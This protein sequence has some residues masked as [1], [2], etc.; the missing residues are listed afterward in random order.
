MGLSD[1]FDRFDEEGHASPVV[2]G[3]P[4][5]HRRESIVSENSRES[6]ASRR[7]SLLQD[8]P[9]AMAH[10][11]FGTQGKRGWIISPS[12]PFA[13]FVLYI[14]TLLLLYT[15]LVVP[16]VVAFFWDNPDPCWRNPLLP[17]DMF[18]DTFFLCE[19]LINFRK[20][21]HV[22]GIYTQDAKVIAWQ[23]IKGDLPFDVFTSIPVSFLE[24]FALQGCEPGGSSAHVNLRFT[25]L[26]KP[27]RLV[28]LV[29]VL[30]AIRDLAVVG[31]VERL[32]KI[33]AMAFRLVRVVFSIGCVTHLVSCIFWFTKVV[34]SDQEDVYEFLESNGLS[35]DASVT[36]KYIISTY[37][38][39]TVFTT[40]GFGDISASN[41]S[42]QLLCIGMMLL[43]VMVFGTLLSEVE[44]GIFELRKFA[45][46]K[47][48]ILY[49]L[50]NFLRMKEVSSATERQLLNWVEFE[51]DVQQRVEWEDE[52]QRFF[53]APMRSAI[54][55]QHA[56]ARLS[57]LEVL[58]LGLS[59]EQQQE[60]YG[61]MMEK[62]WIVT[63]QK[64]QTIADSRSPLQGMF[65]IEQ[66]SV[67]VE[68][69]AG[70]SIQMLNA[71]EVFGDAALVGDCNSESEYGI[72]VAYLANAH[73]CC[74]FFAVAD[75]EATLDAFPGAHEALAE[76]AARRLM[77]LRGMLN[78]TGSTSTPR[79]HLAR[80][81]W[82]SLARKLQR[83]Q[84]LNQVGTSFASKFPS[85][86]ATL[87]KELS[88]HKSSANKQL[89]AS[90]NGTGSNL[91]SSRPP[92]PDRKSVV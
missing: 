64:G 48:H 20:G 54:N 33:P 58:E 70:T 67:R 3:A 32:F 85:V 82:L 12:S 84:K 65:L 55:Y 44:G 18:V 86:F 90:A 72:Q 66:G 34:S 35:R 19:I 47:N 11:I 76:K 60:L 14:S 46:E 87:T 59:D 43:G 51:V 53:A 9:K 31:T 89:L 68:N 27:L 79:F 29:K 5:R 26:I 1:R 40:V 52:C 62:S 37:F 8:G 63:F 74:A 38:T 77:D 56:S 81:R 13:Q 50:K 6:Q 22:G 21:T 88:T 25:R 73:L 49:Q 24:H 4:K 91:N 23:Y 28:R 71:G 36:Q 69:E 57:H 41:S 30:R 17:F 39:C 7:G 61:R 78:R 83:K 75:F 16:I 45:R 2:E 92:P 10:K 42:E 15:G 80:A